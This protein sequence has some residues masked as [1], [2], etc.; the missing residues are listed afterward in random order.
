MSFLFFLQEL[1][2]LVR[3]LSG[4]L[5]LLLGILEVFFEFLDLVVT[6]FERLLIGFHYSA[7]IDDAIT[8]S[9]QLLELRGRE[10]VSGRQWRVHS[11]MLDRLLVDILV[12]L[13]IIS[14]I[15]EHRLLL[16][17]YLHLRLK[18]LSLLLE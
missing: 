8:S 6:L 18:G 14:E 7:Q 11:L 3:P 15:I 2:T 17:K 5:L 9:W 1:L 12:L 16:V 10:L 4:L 13:Q